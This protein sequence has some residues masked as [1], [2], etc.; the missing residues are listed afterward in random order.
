MVEDARRVQVLMR[1][2]QPNRRPRN[3]G[4]MPLVLFRF[5]RAADNLTTE[6]FRARHGLPSAVMETLRD[7]EEL[8]PKLRIAAAKIARRHRAK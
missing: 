7:V 4:M 6:C 3:V 8:L 1:I 2:S 5:Q